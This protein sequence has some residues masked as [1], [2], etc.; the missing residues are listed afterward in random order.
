ML[1][2]KSILKEK[3]KDDGIRISV[4]SRHTLND[5]LTPD[6]RITQDSFD[7]HLQTLG[8]PAKLIG[9]YYKRGLSWNDYK[10]RYTEHLRNPQ[11]A[12]TVRLLAERATKHDIT[13]LC[14]E[15]TP[16]YCHRSL[17]AQECKIYEPSLTI[18]HR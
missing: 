15:E 2:T 16:E 7:E 14:I 10:T 12:E 4:M 11:V 13:L 18:V 8:P 5:G 3:S 17:L 9:D 6:N 1:Y